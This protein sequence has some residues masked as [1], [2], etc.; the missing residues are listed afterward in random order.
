MTRPI[1]SIADS[2]TQLLVC[3]AF[4]LYHGPLIR[5]VKLRVAH[6]PG[7][8]GTFSLAPRVSDPYM[9]HGTCMTH[10]PWGMPGSLTSGFI[11]SQWRGKRSRHCTTRNFTYLARGPFDPIW[12]IPGELIFVLVLYSMYI[13]KILVSDGYPTIILHIQTLMP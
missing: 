5:Y 6:A 1:V 13:P 10:V 11:W 9:H 12:S 2:S 7:M 3:R 8:P 4:N